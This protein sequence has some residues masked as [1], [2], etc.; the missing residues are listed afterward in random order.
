MVTTETF[1]VPRHPAEA[2]ESMLVPALFEPWA[3]M[4]V[5]AAGIGADDRILDVACGTGIVARVAADRVGGDPS[6]ASTGARRC[7]R[8]PGASV[9][10]SSG[11][12]PTRA[13]CRSSRDR[14]TS[15]SARPR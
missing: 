5:D 12:K 11:V 2:Y 7:W 14:S 4:L 15:C 1:R 13:G 3:Q 6:W 10:T 8:S 9:P